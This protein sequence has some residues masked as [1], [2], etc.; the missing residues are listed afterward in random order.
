MRDIR[1]ICEA[2]TAE[3]R[4]WFPDIAG[5][6]WRSTLEFAMRNFKD[7]SFI[8][9]YLSPKLIRDFHFF[10]VLDDDHSDKLM[11]SAI[12]NEDGYR[13]IRS[14]LTEQYNMGSREPDIQVWSVNVTT[15]RALTLRHPQFQRR[16]L[17]QHTDEVLK[18]VARLW[19][20]DVH[21]ETVDTDGIVLHTLHSKV[22]VN[23]RM[24]N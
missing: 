5:G 16:P 18:H 4:A 11:I 24:A 14:Q 8:A 2:P 21:L 20:F 10:S 6:D 3:D 19:G 1:R 23:S 12:H 22:D 17:N 7:E 15:D 13:H 9:Q